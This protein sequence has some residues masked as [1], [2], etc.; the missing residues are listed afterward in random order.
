MGTWGTGLFQDDFALDIKESYRERLKKGEDGEI[1]TASLIE[2]HQDELNDPDT[3]TVFWLA[4]ADT[5]WKLGRLEPKVKENA[6][7]CIL[8]GSDLERWENSARITYRSRQRVLS[9]LES[10]LLSP[11]PEKKI[12]RSSIPKPY[13][14]GWNNG[15]VYALKLCSEEAGKLK[16]AGRYLLLQMVD[17]Y[18]WDEVKTI[19]IVY[20]KLTKDAELPK[21]IE[22]YNACEFVQVGFTNYKDRLLS[23][24][25]KMTKEEIEKLLKVEYRMDEYGFLPQ[26]RFKLITTS[27]RVIPKSLIYVGNFEDAAKPENEFVQHKKINICSSFW[28]KDG[29]EL[30]DFVLSSYRYHNLREGEIYTDP[31]LS[32]ESLLEGIIKACSMVQP[33]D[34]KEGKI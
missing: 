26:Y 29:I 5:Q 11:Q 24:M 3:K 32:S 6:L 16:L 18:L 20:V 13:F 7:Q 34:N 21:T 17:T 31:S 23:L 19:P 30:E 15:D 4:L 33:Q 1:I 27:N 2:E 9:T 22:E 28:G 8:D 25:G 12:L 10:R 14:C